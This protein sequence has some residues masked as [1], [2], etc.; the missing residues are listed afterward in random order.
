VSADARHR[1]ATNLEY[2]EQVKAK[3]LA[4]S[5]SARQA[6]GSAAVC[7]AR[8]IRTARRPHLAR[9]RTGAA[10]EY[11]CIIA[12]NRGGI[13]PDHRGLNDLPFG[14][15]LRH[16]WDRTRGRERAVWVRT[17]RGDKC[18]NCGAQRPTPE[19]TVCHV[20][21]LTIVQVIET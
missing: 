18:S 1:Y 10:R 21:N 12:A 19:A 6:L 14:Q 11:G 17:D 7:R 20:C 15:Q 16:A 13:V 5:R 2:R 8:S 3:A 9:T 4:R